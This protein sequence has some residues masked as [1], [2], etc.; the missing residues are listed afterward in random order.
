MTKII[1]NSKG[2]KKPRYEGKVNTDT[3]IPDG[4]GKL[5]FAN[6]DNLDA[7]FTNGFIRG[8]EGTFAY[9]AGD[10]YKGTINNNLPTGKGIYYYAN[11]DYFEGEFRNDHPVI[12]IYHHEWGTFEIKAEDIQRILTRD[13][14]PLVSSTHEQSTSTQSP[15]TTENPIR[16]IKYSNGDKYEGEWTNGQCNGKGTYYWKN[17]DKY[18]GDWKD[19][20]VNGHG[21]FYWADGGKYV[22]E[23][24]NNSFNGYGVRHFAS[25]AKYAG[26]WKDGKK[27]GEGTYSWANGDRYEGD[28]KDD[29]RH[30]FGILYNA[31]GSI[32][33]KGEWENDR[34]KPSTVTINYP[35]G[36]K[37]IGTV[38]ANGKPHGNG[39]RYFANGKIE[40]QGEWE[41]GRRN[42]IGTLYYD[43]EASLKYQGE[44]KD[45]EPNG[46]GTAYSFVGDTYI[47]MF[48]GEWRDGLLNGHVVSYNWDGS[49]LS[50]NEWENGKKKKGGLFRR[51]KK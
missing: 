31:D 17:G 50:E 27:D 36:E 1:Y 39:T 6:G 16:T 46:K 42:G 15:T 34:Q 28:F 37:Y 3:K 7:E 24:K 2:D 45:D 38:N 4:R 32:A 23:F 29:K 48:E 10:T 30:G 40:Y 14:E 51:F 49:I 43:K 41:N 12:G 44:F 33:Y 25:G 5:T 9:T 21:T 19:D 47:K 8:K 26:N 35:K 22:G 18:E 11:G 20:K 13:N